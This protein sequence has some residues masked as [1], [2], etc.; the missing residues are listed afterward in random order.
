[1]RGT[2]WLL[3]AALA[4][5]WGGS[6]F[7]NELVVDELAT[8][9]VVLFRVGI[10]AIVL[11][12]VVF[13]S[14]QRPP[15]RLKTWGLYL[16]MGAI[17]NV[18]P[19]SLIVWGQTG[20]TSSL[21]SI[22]NATSPIFMVII[23]AFWL[24]DE[25][26]TRGK[27]LAVLVGFAGVVIMIGPDAIGDLGGSVLHQM[28]ILGAAFS[29]AVAGGFGKRFGSMGITPAVSAA[30]QVT[31]S[32]LIL[33]PIVIMSGHAEG[34]ATVS[35]Q[36]WL[37]VIGLGVVCTAVAYLIYFRLL[38][39]AGATNLVLVTFLIPVSAILLGV[40]VLDETLRPQEI[41][42]MLT[43]FAALLLIDGRLLRIGRNNK[44]PG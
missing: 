36:A 28:A 18:I 33:L 11:W 42:G 25:P 21:A 43:I 20:T 2:D 38:A 41:I 10:A 12:V 31:M 27:F 1:M 34:L 29:Y 39:S 13:A 7:L 6:F 30:T 23:A 24:H 9:V 22:L 5:I 26:V 35:S 16:V 44:Q 4:F 32:T 40:G 3:L 19:F 14:G 17:N 8:F 15:A 37:S